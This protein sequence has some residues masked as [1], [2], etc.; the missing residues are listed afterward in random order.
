[1]TL[2]IAERVFLKVPKSGPLL[3]YQMPTLVRGTKKHNKHLCQANG[4]QP[5][6]ERRDRLSTSSKVAA[7]SSL[8]P[9]CP[10]RASC[11][12]CYNPSSLR[13]GKYLDVVRHHQLVGK[14]DEFGAYVVQL[15]CML[16]I[17]LCTPQIHV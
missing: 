3:D 14:Y 7:R 9:L 11:P 4:G 5:P 17:E 10:V 15:G 12:L 13:R 8:Q 1:M 2:T 16:D 6:G